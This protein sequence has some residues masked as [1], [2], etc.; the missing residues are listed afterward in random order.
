ML[1]RSNRYISRN[2]DIGNFCV[3]FHHWVFEKVPLFDGS[4]LWSKASRYWG[5][6]ARREKEKDRRVSVFERNFD[7]GFPVG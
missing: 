6:R 3:G 2:A 4:C 5:N 1:F 7:F